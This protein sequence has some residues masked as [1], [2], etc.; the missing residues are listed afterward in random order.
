MTIQPWVVYSVL[1][2]FSA[3]L[4]ACLIMIYSMASKKN[5][6]ISVSALMTSLYGKKTYIVGTALLLVDQIH[7]LGW[8]SDPTTG[9]VEKILL[10]LAAFTLKAAQNRAE[11]G[12]KQILAMNRKIILD[13]QQSV[14]ATLKKEE[15]RS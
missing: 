15:D 1:G 5:P 4:V 3:A 12:Q 13:H 11:E 14:A 9:R 6:A 2:S 7:S 8:L 10:V